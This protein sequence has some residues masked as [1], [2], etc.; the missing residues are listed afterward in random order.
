MQ[1]FSLLISAI[2]Q[3]IL[4]SIIPF[5]W[6]LIFGRKEA[7]FFEWL[8]FKK[9]VIKNKVRYFMIFVTTIMFLLIPSFLIVPY[10]V[11][12]SVLATTQFY[13]QGATALVPALIYAFVQTS[14]SEEIF[15][16][17]FLTKRLI[18]QFGFHIGNGIQGLL[19]GLLHGVMFVSSAGIVGAIIIVL[20]TGIAGWLMGWINEKESDGSIVSSWLLHGFVNFL[21]S[22]FAMFVIL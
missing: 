3:V 9:P 7:S 17:G 16:R 20:L 13:G 19:F 22:I 5:V 10:F 2:L 18:L 11:D 1:I 14:L 4:F 12:K 15:F 6:W 8:G 21:A